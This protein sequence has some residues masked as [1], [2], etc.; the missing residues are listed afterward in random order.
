MGAASMEGAAASVSHWGIL[1]HKLRNNSGGGAE[2]GVVDV[3]AGLTH[4]FRTSGAV[5]ARDVFCLHKAFGSRI[6]MRGVAC[7]KAQL[8]AI[9]R[10][11]K[12][13]PRVR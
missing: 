1:F 7:Q 10:N 2:E 4:F 5:E 11:A 12:A 9:E 6:S 13:C 8:E 3:C